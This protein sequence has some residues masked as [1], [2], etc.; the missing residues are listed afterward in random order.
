[1][2]P[3]PAT[4]EPAFGMP[5]TLLAGLPQPC[6]NALEASRLDHPRMDDKLIGPKPYPVS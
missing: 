1:M 6:Y 5:K 2:I 3:S 4:L